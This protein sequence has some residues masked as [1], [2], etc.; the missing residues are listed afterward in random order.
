MLPVHGGLFVVVLVCFL[1]LFCFL[2][3]WVFWLFL[4]GG[5]VGEGG[6]RRGNTRE[7]I[8]LKHVPREQWQLQVQRGIKTV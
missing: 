2:F 4:C 1:W 6:L 3:V 7:N 5:F 8:F